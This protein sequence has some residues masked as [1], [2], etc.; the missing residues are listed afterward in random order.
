MTAW[1]AFATAALLPLLLLALG[2]GNNTA[3][4]PS[5]TSSTS[6]TSTT[7][8]TSVTYAGTLDPGAFRFYS[9]NVTTAGS[10]TAL[11]ASVTAADTRLPIDAPLEIGVGVPSGT[12][13]ATTS[14]QVLSPGLVSQMTVTLA[15]GTYCLRVADSG[16]LKA[17]AA[18]A[19][20]F[21]H[22]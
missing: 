16:A 17:P 21:T 10:V 6:S 7:T 13:C 5:S 12:D 14:T 20:R 9:F 4:S 19:V 15:A 8:P 18:F 2:C 3:T 1:S 11:L 22:T